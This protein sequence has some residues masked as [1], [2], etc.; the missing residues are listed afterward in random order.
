MLA[1]NVLVD[2]AVLGVRLNM[3]EG[4]K[5]EGSRADDELNENQPPTEW[6]SVT[7]NSTEN[8]YRYVDVG[9]VIHQVSH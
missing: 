4:R 5:N 8:S 7:G 1:R 6:N 3:V 9:Y 2:V